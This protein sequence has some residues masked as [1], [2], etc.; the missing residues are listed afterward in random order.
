MSLIKLFKQLVIFTI[1]WMLSSFWIYN[2]L[3][4]HTVYYFKNSHLTPKKGIPFILTDQL[5]YHIDNT[6]MESKVDGGIFEYNIDGSNYITYLHL[7]G[8]ENYSYSLT[9]VNYFNYKY[10]LEMPDPLKTD[11]ENA[12]YF[13][14]S[15][16]NPLEKTYYPSN[17]VKETTFSDEEKRAVYQAT[18]QTASQLLDNLPTPIINLQWFFDW[19][20]KGHKVAKIF[21]LSFLMTTGLTGIK[22]WRK[23]YLKSNSINSNQ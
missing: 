19:T 23:R 18:N 8:N 1:I 21:L 17:G 4:T 14:D 15:H 7:K 10:K 16:F 3:E 20:Y 5:F 9:Q 2:R 6:Y 11:G 12:Y 22:V 13:F